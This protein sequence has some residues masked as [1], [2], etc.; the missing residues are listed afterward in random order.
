MKNLRRYT[1]RI[2]GA[3]LMVLGF[4]AC[5]YQSAETAK[6][7]YLEQME[8]T[9]AWQAQHAEREENKE[10]RKDERSAEKQSAPAP[11]R[12]VPDSK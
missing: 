6:Q 7:F 9:N 5:Y 4:P 2:V 1:F 3:T 8:K 12:L 11:A 10:E